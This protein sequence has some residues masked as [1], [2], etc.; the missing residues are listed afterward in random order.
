MINPS[1]IFRE[2]AVIEEHKEAICKHLFERMMRENPGSMRSVFYDLSSTTFTGSRC[3]L[4]KWGHCK[5]GYDNHVV[6]ALVVNRDGF[7]FY[8]EVLPGGTADSKTIDWLLE[9]VRDRFKI[10]GITLVFDRGM[11]SDDNLDAIENSKIKYISAMDKSQLQSITGLDFTSFSHLDPGKIDEQLDSL[12]DFKKLNDITYYREIKVDGQRRYILCFNPVLF[13][14][15]R[16]A[17]KQAIANFQSFVETLNEELRQA[18]KS[19]QNKATYKKFKDKLTKAKI[20]SFVDV[21]LRVFHVKKS[22]VGS[23]RTYKAEVVVD[24]VAM[25]EA[26]I[27]DGFWLL[28]T[29]HSDKVDNEF[30]FS[31]EDLINPYREKLIIE[32]AFRDIKS[33]IDI[34][35]VF[36]W[37]ELHVKAHYSCCV[38]GHLINRTITQRLHENKGKVT[39]DIVSHERFYKELSDCQIDL[40]EI[41]DTGLSTYNMTI[42]TNAQKEFL[43]RVGLTGL[44][45]FEV[46]NKARNSKIY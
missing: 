17:R 18:K 40:I 1:R 13:K 26:G 32:S 30:E 14:D 33:F 22:T 46:V 6:L 5:E 7:P 38:L 36:V 21:K 39:S 10:K 9:S 45:S 16:K 34:S 8:W 27:L 4:M 35:P 37:T 19:R 44:L 41:K 43:K 3:V 31:S 28:V 25:R 11:V 12:S 2:L 29:N 20:N 15:Q 42:P 23:I 24:D